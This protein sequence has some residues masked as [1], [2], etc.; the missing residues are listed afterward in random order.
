MGKSGFLGSQNVF[1]WRDICWKVFCGSFGFVERAD[2][3]DAGNDFV[4]MDGQRSR[5]GAIQGDLGPLAV[6]SVFS[7]A[8]SCLS[9][10]TYETKIPRL[11]ITFDLSNALTKVFNVI[12]FVVD[13]VATPAELARVLPQDP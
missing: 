10:N 2:C 8:P 6:T 13:N 4:Q 1:G 5:I 7:D 11:A 9:P 12:I 3:R